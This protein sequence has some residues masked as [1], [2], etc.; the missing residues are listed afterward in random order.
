M[1][2]QEMHEAADRLFAVD[3]DDPAI[4][5]AIYVLR[6]AADHLESRDAFDAL[7]AMGAVR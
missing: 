3:C 5:H 1:T 6:T 4:S 2:P 7:R